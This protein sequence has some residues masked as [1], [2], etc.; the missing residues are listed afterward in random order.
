MT[1][2]L[3]GP[4][5]GSGTTGKLGHAWVVLGSVHGAGGVGGGV[6]YLCYQ[7]NFGMIKLVFHFKTQTNLE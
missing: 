2:G 5:L 4:G 6:A 7:D 1:P 3:A